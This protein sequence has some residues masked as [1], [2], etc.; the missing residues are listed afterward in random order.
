MGWQPVG[1]CPEDDGQNYSGGT[2]IDISGGTISNTGDTDPS[3]DVEVGDNAGGDLGGAY[4][5]PDVE[6]IQG[7]SVSPN[8]PSNGEVLKWD[9]SQWE[10]AQDD[11]QNYSGGTGIDISGGTIT[12]TGDTDPSDDIESGDSAGGDLGGDYPNPDVEGIQGLPIF[13][14]PSGIQ[15]LTSTGQGGLEWM[16]QQAAVW[17]ESGSSAYYPNST[18]GVE[19]QESR[20]TFRSG[21]SDE[22]YIE[23]LGTPSSNF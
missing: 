1:A 16:D 6:G 4:P 2:G 11:G 7:R 20:I 5:N 23:S 3:D 15:V 22:F 13:N 8:A 12:N 17:Q 10:P 9:G 19:V 14:T 21:A 18:D